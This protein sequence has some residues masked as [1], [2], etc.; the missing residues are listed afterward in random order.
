MIIWGYIMENQ[1]ETKIRKQNGN[2][3]Y[4]FYRWH[5]RSS[6]AT[7]FRVLGGTAPTPPVNNL[8]L[9]GNMLFLG[10]AGGLC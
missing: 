4:G 7:Q 1:M 3:C 10:R 8:K 9:G 6:P 5:Y 2:W